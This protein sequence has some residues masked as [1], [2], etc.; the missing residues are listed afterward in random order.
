MHVERWNN[1]IALIVAQLKTFQTVSVDWTVRFDHTD[2]ANQLE[3]C[4]LHRFESTTQVL[5]LDRPYELLFKGFS[6]TTR[7]QIRRAKRK[8]VIVSRATQEV[9]VARYY[10]LYKNI[11]E[12][13]GRETIFSK[14]LLNELFKLTDDVIL[15]TA[16]IDNEVIGG[17][18]YIRDGDSLFYFQGAMN[19]A[20]KELFPYYAITDSAISLA[21]N[22]AMKSFNMG[23]SAGIASLERF[24]SFWGTQKLPYW[25]FTWA[26]PIW[27]TAGKVK[28]HVQILLPKSTQINSPM[29]SGTPWSERAKLGE[30]EAVLDVNSPERV[31]L[32]MHG[33]NLVAARKTLSLLRQ[34]VDSTRVV[35]L[36]FGCGTGRMVRFFGKNGCDVLGLD[37]TIEMLRHAKKHGLPSTAWLSHF[38]GVSIPAKDQSIDIVWV[39]GVL[40]YTLFPPT[41]KCRHGNLEV[42]KTT[43]ASVNGT[44]N[45]VFVPTYFEVAREMYRVLKPGGIVANNEMW[46]DAQPDV[47]TRDFESAGFV[48]EQSAILRRYT[49]RLEKITEFHKSFRLA[50]WLVLSMARTCANLRFLWDNPSRAGNDFRDYL[51]IW[52][53][54]E[55]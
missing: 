24:K 1:C 22:E 50:P 12:Q 6:Q 33:A 2:L 55:A 39:C 46:V 48:T 9:D 44:A 5:Y 32:L 14:E 25:T 7:N 23:G 51:F 27:K 20:R 4:G 10:D 40:K 21:C 53:K 26:N 13:R 42:G 28:K 41:A 49:G 18:W 16:R 43:A 37:V 38:D 35:L 45:N 29:S 15:L 8:G 30:L 31:L 19:Y 54:P 3:N 11:N 17:G 52:R 34:R 36:D 47:F